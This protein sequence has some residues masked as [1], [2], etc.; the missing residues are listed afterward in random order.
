LAWCQAQF[1]PCNFESPQ[2]S[3]TTRLS[4]S[5]FAFKLLAFAFKQGRHL[6][7]IRLREFRARGSDDKLPLQQSETNAA[8][9]QILLAD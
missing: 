3:V 1:L 4:F 5:E 6:V 7:Q 2:R 8:C 9:R